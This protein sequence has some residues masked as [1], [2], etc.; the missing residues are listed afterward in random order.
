MR[1][2]SAQFAQYFEQGFR[3]KNL[4]SLD[5]RVLKDRVFLDAAKEYRASHPNDEVA[6]RREARA[7]DTISIRETNPLYGPVYRQ[8]T[9]LLKIIEYAFYGALRDEGMSHE[10]ASQE[11]VLLYKNTKSKV[12]SR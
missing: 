11:V 2:S 12:F 1:E 9:R 8:E 10:R 6:L 7:K 4:S 3:F 5:V